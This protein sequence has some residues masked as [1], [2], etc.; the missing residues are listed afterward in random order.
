MP[1][2]CS[3]LDPLHVNGSGRKCLGLRI[4][5]QSNSLLCPGCCQAAERY[6]RSIR[7]YMWRIFHHPHDLCFVDG[8]DSLE[9]HELSHFLQNTSP[10]TYSSIHVTGHRYIKLTVTTKSLT[11]VMLLNVKGSPRTLFCWRRSLSG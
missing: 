1:S 8:K 3:T 6:L 2:K 11:M 7:L 4:G 5:F 9:S 10:L